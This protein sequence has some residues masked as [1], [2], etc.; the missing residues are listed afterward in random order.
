MQRTMMF[1]IATAMALLTAWAVYSGIRLHRL[2]NELATL[3]PTQSPD[4]EGAG[5]PKQSEG[6]AN[7]SNLSASSPRE[8]ERLRSGLSAANQR[9]TALESA[10]TK[11]QTSPPPPQDPEQAGGRRQPVLSLVEGEA[12]GKANTQDGASSGWRPSVRS[13][14]AR[15]DDLTRRID[16]LDAATL[17]AS[18]KA[19]DQVSS[20]VN[21]ELEAF[22][23][24]RRQRREAMSEQISDELVN[25]FAA[26]AGLSDEQVGALYPDFTSYRQSVR[27][28][29]RAMA[30]GEKDFPEV[31]EAMSEAREALD[32]RAKEVLDDKQFGLYKQEMDERSGGPG[33]LF[34]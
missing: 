14:Q 6:P 16:S 27:G 32:S 9:L 22:R 11:L 15:L 24:E 29:W 7:V 26:D 19:K 28:A 20:L 8:L 21:K 5:R 17:L 12:G 18:P 13:L 1:V 2:S 30:K 25:K 33:G 31:H 3:S 4:R 34:R 23:T 10:L